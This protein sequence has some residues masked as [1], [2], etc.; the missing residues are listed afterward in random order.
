MPVAVAESPLVS[1]DIKEIRKHYG[2]Q[3]DVK[4]KGFVCF[5]SNVRFCIICNDVMQIKSS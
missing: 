3:C 5:F 2:L 1:N 4:S